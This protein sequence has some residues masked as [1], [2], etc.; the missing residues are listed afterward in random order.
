MF[1]SAIGD[2][3]SKASS[4]LRSTSGKRLLARR[5]PPLG[6]PRCAFSKDDL[7]VA[8]IANNI[9]FKTRTAEELRVLPDD[10]IVRY[11]HSST[12]SLEEKAETQC[13]H[14]KPFPPTGLSCFCWKRE[15]APSFCCA[16]AG[17]SCPIRGG[18]R[19]R[20]L[21][22]PVSTW[23]RLTCAALDEAAHP[24]TYQPTPSSILSGTW[25]GS[26]GHLAKSVLSSSGTIGARRSP[27]TR[28]CF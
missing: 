5:S 17:R 21:R 12:I 26:W 20:P 4:E 10:P 19:F 13:R 14:R 15:R 23:W 2:A 11:Q 22:R 18:T 27:G 6:S 16:M 28:R 25:S 3:Q 1:S 7:T 8:S 9:G 24:P